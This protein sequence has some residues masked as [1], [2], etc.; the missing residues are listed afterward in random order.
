[1]RRMLNYASFML[2]AIVGGLFVPKPDVIY[3]WHPPL[4]IGV[5]AWAVSRLRRAPFVYDVQDIWPESAVL[6]GVVKPGRLYGM[7]MGLERF[8]Y[9]RAD[10]LLV[11]TAGAKENLVAKG[12]PREKI[13]VFY[14]WAD[15]DLFSQA[16][17]GVARG[18]RQQHDWGDKF[19]VLFAGN[20]GLVQGLD[21][22][23]TAMKRLPRESRARLVL[24]G[25]GSDAGRLRRIAAELDLGERV[26][27]IDRRP[28]SEMPAFL[29][30]ADVL[31]VHVRASALSSLILPS[32]TLTYMAS[33]RPVLA[34]AIGAA[35]DLIEQ[36]GAGVTV[37][38]D[39]PD[40]LAHAIVRLEGTPEEER[41]AMGRN[42]RSYLLANLSKEALMDEHE[43]VLVDVARRSPVTRGRQ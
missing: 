12:V 34:G 27:F 39:D 11:V 36:A 22:A 5:A 8:V 42:G 4:S 3:V 35:A 10:H 15:E 23:L 18:I 21:T 38:P 40:A 7:M 41:S 1:G 2:S 26:Q 31:F 30:A 33:G 37:P 29:A 17:T 13:T 20:L 25:D 16:D 32:K 24:L 14:P 19:I 9:R 28:I 6:S 43:Q